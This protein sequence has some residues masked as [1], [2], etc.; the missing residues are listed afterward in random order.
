MAT[1]LTTNWIDQKGIKTAMDL[2][3]HVNENLH[4]FWV[5]QRDALEELEHEFSLKEHAEYRKIRKLVG[6]ILIEMM[7]LMDHFQ[8]AQNFGDDVTI[9]LPRE[10]ASKAEVAAGDMS[11]VLGQASQTLL[12]LHSQITSNDSGNIDSGIMAAMAL[13]GRGLGNI[14]ETE[15]L[16]LEQLARYILKGLS[17]KQTATTA[18]AA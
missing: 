3:V 16:I 8:K 15:G 17:E 1:W 14:A 2:V 11:Y 18:L 12:H 4:K 7:N 9:Y 10:F 6:D 13:S 5:E